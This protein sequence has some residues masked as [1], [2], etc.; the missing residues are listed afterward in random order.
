MPTPP[1]DASPIK[2]ADLRAVEPSIVLPKRGASPSSSLYRSVYRQANPSYSSL[3][4]STSSLPGSG[5]SSG[6]ATPTG[7]RPESALSPGGSVRPRSPAVAPTSE[8]SGLRSLIQR[9][10]APH[11]TV[12][13]SQ[14]TEELLQGKGFPGG[15]LQLIRPFG[16]CINGKV[17]VRDS[18]G[19]SKSW[20]DFGL[21]ITGLEDGLNPPKPPNAARR[22]AEAA[23]RGEKALDG[24]LE[25]TLPRDLFPAWARTGGD[26]AQIEEV[27]DRHLEYAEVQNAAPSKDPYAQLQEALGSSTPSEIPS[28]FYSLY[29]R[30]LLSA[31]PMSPHE[32]FS[33]PAACIIAISSRN[34]APIED[35]RRL[36]NATNT[37]DL[38][39]PQ[40]VNNE[41]LRYYVLV[42][43]EDHDDIQKSTAL[44]EQMKRHFGLH[45]H[46]LRLRSNQCLPSDDDSVR[47]PA[48]EWVSAA[49][50][51]DEIQR[52]GKRSHSHTQ[53]LAAH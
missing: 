29:L 34:A 14:D 10:F 19:A 13:S 53:P 41:Y 50:E 4:A 38:R 18:I 6:T 45:C 44:Y 9:A 2:S 21:R 26:V 23:S 3:F 22:S 24:L 40:W 32:T 49:E 39:L 12:L 16:E 42:H 5:A 27:V 17:T 33:H 35:L 8:P 25:S 15:F 7:L 47:L 51:L 11:V 28:P 43:D 48:A 37:G 1:R 36:Y 20:D 46:L 31:L 30:R 52:R